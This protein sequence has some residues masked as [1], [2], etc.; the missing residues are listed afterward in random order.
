M[1][2]IV[3]KVTELCYNIYKGMPCMYTPAHMVDL[4]ILVETKCK[5]TSCYGYRII[6]QQYVQATR[7]C[8]PCMYTQADIVHRIILAETMCKGLFVCFD[9]LLPTV[10]T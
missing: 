10:P 4:I 3:D 8:M 1:F 7:V 5:S 6:L 2:K 9:S